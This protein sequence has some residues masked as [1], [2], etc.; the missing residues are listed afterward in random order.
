MK[1]M[2]KEQRLYRNRTST[3]VKQIELIKNNKNRRGKSKW[4]WKM[5]R[6]QI[7]K[8]WYESIKIEIGISPNYIC[9]HNRCKCIK[10]FEV[11]CGLVY[12]N[13][14]LKKYLRY[15]DKH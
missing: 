9:N 3:F 8:R 1:N 13:V 4:K 2:N 5:R 6:R 7:L 14:R 15:S 11:F 12:Q 10:L